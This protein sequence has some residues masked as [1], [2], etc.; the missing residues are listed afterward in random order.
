M[1]FAKAVTHDDQ[2]FTDFCRTVYDKKHH[3]FLAQRKD[4]VSWHP[5]QTEAQFAF[6]KYI[7]LSSGS[8]LSNV[9]AT[10][11]LRDLGNFVSSDGLVPRSLGKLFKMV[12]EIPV[13][14]FQEIPLSLYGFGDARLAGIR[15]YVYARS[16]VE[17]I[18]YLLRNPNFVGKMEYAPRAEKA[19]DGSRMYSEHVTGDWFH[20]VDAEIPNNGTLIGLYLYSDKTCV[21]VFGSTSMYPVYIA[22][23]NVARDARKLVRGRVLVAFLPVVEKAIPKTTKLSASVKSLLVQFVFHRAIEEIFFDFDFDGVSYGAAEVDGFY[24]DDPDGCLRWFFPRVAVYV[25]DWPEAKVISCT[26]SGKTKYPCHRC[27]VL[28]VES[29]L[30]EQ[31]GDATSARSLAWYS[32]VC[33]R[34]ND[35]LIRKKM[36]RDEILKGESVRATW[37]VFPKFKGFDPYADGL[38]TERMH[39]TDQGIFKRMMVEWLPGY[40]KGVCILAYEAT[41]P[42]ASSTN[43]GVRD[44]N[45]IIAELDAR[46]AKLPLM[47]GHGGMRRFE[48]GVSELSNVTANEWR[49]MMKQVLLVLPGLL[50]GELLQYEAPLLRVFQSFVEW[51]ALVRKRAHTDASLALLTETYGKWCAEVR[52]V[53]GPFVDDENGFRFPKFHAGIHFEVDIRNHG[54]YDSAETY[55]CE[56]KLTKRI[57]QMHT[58][59]RKGGE[60]ARQVCSYLNRIEGVRYLCNLMS[61][62]DVN[63]DA[64]DKAGIDEAALDT[65]EKDVA[66]HDTA[67]KDVDGAAEKAMDAEIEFVAPTSKK[68]IRVAFKGRGS[69]TSLVVYNPGYVPANPALQPHDAS[70]LDSFR[71]DMQPELINLPAALKSYVGGGHVGDNAVVRFNSV[72]VWALPSDTPNDFLRVVGSESFYNTARFDDVGVHSDDN[73]VWYASVRMVFMC[74]VICDGKTD[75]RALAFVRWYHSYPREKQDI[76]KL[77]GMRM[78]CDRST[79]GKETYDVIRIDSIKSRVHMAPMWDAAHAKRGNVYWANTYATAW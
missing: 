78:L 10:N 24:C 30:V 49:D 18:T 67:E 15:L 14:C 70:V 8:K 60:S 4:A 31:S 38:V 77:N 61:V 73:D 63:E 7:V 28:Y 64:L 72:Q 42:E 76:C 12:G 5:F 52:E 32:E 20:R 19:A 66:A 11:L 39:Q 50:K 51:Y 46:F 53:F 9:E 44:G 35:P 26:R 68:G 55:E 75:T 25:A 59:K 74:E 6:A 43:V 16:P 29:E 58:N 71:A 69:K 33:G 79:N 17:C 41:H 57:Y 3:T 56:H 40:I 37:S 2:Y 34:A 54:C 13:P 36:D 23:T 27:D 48:N 21:T 47:K 1:R 62:P 65:A 22:L 45:V